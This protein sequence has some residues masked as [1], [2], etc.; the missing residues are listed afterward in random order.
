MGLVQK[1]K[2]L[3]LES[4][5]DQLP[6]TIFEGCIGFDLQKSYVEI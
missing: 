2:S 6:T 3:V 5:K 1:S 4:S